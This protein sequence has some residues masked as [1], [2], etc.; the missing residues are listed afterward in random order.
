VNAV[1]GIAFALLCATTMVLVR[2]AVPGEMRDPGVWITDPSL[3]RW[4][5]LGLQL[6]PLVAIVFLW[7]MAALRSRIATLENQFFSTLYLGSGFVFVAMLFAAGAVAHGILATFDGSTANPLQD[8]AYVFA[9]STDYALMNTFAA[10]AAA[11]FMS[12]S[13]TIGHRSQTMLRY[14]YTLGYLFGLVL[15]VVITDSA[16]VFL[17]FPLWTLIVSVGF[18][19]ADARQERGP[20]VTVTAAASPTR[21]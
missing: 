11:M 14:E 8:S 13:S 15:L 6:V 19:R 5:E 17:L 21:V 1:I 18:L 4:V 10:K 20:T 7:F 12:I 2:V 3:R 9:R 16:W